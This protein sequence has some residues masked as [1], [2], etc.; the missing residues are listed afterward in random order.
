M[1]LTFNLT[2]WCKMVEFVTFSTLLTLCWAHRTIMD[3]STSSITTTTTI[4]T[5]GGTTRGRRRRTTPRHFWWATKLPWLEFLERLRTCV[6]LNGKLGFNGLM[7]F[8]KLNCDTQELNRIL[9]EVHAPIPGPVIQ[10][11]SVTNKFIFIIPK[12]TC[13]SNVI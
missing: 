1:C 3:V 11:L 10:L 5:T 6:R 12:V 9:T 2:A 13:L 8:S 7:L 4:G